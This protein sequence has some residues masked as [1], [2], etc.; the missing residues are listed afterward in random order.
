MLFDYYYS[1]AHKT[2]ARRTLR[3]NIEYTHVTVH[4]H[5]DEEFERIV[6]EDAVLVAIE[7]VREIGGRQ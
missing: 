6:P 5:S 2:E 7:D 1:E 4:E 3:S